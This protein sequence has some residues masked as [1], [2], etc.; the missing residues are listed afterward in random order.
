MAS[1]KMEILRTMYNK[2]K[3][4]PKSGSLAKPVHWV[5]EKLSFLEQHS[6]SRPFTRTLDSEVRNRTF[7]LC[8]N[9]ALMPKFKRLNFVIIL[10]Y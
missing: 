7:I 10:K 4:L 2:Y 8:V 3:K 9:Y 6:K 1:K 5:V